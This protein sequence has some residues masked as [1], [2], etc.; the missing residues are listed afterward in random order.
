MAGMRGSD[1]KQDAM[2]SYVSPEQ[3]VPAE[4]PLRPLRAM[5][6]EILKRMSLRLAKLCVDTGR[7]SIPSEGLL[8]VLLLQICHTVHSER[9]LNE[10]VATV[11]F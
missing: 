4:L 6:D 11:F 5:M 9:L 2:F 3:G 8:R 7:P 1:Q 10:E